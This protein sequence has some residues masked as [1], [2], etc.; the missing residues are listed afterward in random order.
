MEVNEKSHIVILGKKNSVT[1][2]MIDGIVY[3]AKED[4]NFVEVIC[5]S[6]AKYFGLKCFSY[7]PL[8]IDDKIVNIL[9]AQFFLG[10]IFPS[11]PINYVFSKD[12]KYEGVF[13]KASEVLSSLQREC[14]LYDVWNIIEEKFPNNY[15]KLVREVVL[16]Y[17]FD[18]LLFNIDREPLNYGFLNGKDLVI[19]DNKESFIGW[20]KG[21]VSEDGNYFLKNI[22]EDIEKF[23]LTSS[24]EYLELFWSILNELTPKILYKIIKDIEIKHNIVIGDKKRILMKY[25]SNYYKVYNIL[26]KYR[27]GIIR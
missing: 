27:R 5:S 17:F 23:C 20:G 15:Q 11:L 13:L 16:M 18:S 25:T 6:L 2:V 8:V 24:E 26:N 4:K 12:I 22:Y 14:S 7:E 19:F 9:G 1:K 21:L 10:G 3:Y